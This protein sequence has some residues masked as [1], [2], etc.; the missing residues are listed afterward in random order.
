M[1]VD[2]L[3]RDVSPDGISC[4]PGC[5]ELGENLFILELNLCCL[6]ASVDASVDTTDCRK[7]NCH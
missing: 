5:D 1:F 4:C 3:Q 2:T 7:G 6:D